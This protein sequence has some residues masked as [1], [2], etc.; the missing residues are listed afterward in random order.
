M[1]VFRPS[2]RNAVF[3]NIPVR[4]SDSKSVGSAHVPSIGDVGIWLRHYLA[5]SA[6]LI[7][8]AP[9]FCWNRL[10][11]ANALQAADPSQDMIPRAPSVRPS[12]YTSLDL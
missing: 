3:Q 6:G 8:T 4:S 9:S 11:E 10:G 1:Q 7:A 2:P 5:R 12:R